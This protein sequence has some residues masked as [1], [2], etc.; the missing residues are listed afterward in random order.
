MNSHTEQTPWKTYRSS[1]IFFLQQS[2]TG[3]RQTPGRVFAALAK[4]DKLED[5]FFD[6]TYSAFA[7]AIDATAFWLDDALGGA[8]PKESKFNDD[9][10]TVPYIGMSVA[11]IVRSTRAAWLP[12]LIICRPR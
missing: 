4:G 5:G 1:N 6:L 3:P 7:K 12:Y 10:P 11:R 9:F 8:I 2:I